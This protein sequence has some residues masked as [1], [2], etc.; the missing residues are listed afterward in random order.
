MGKNPGAKKQKEKKHKER[1]FDLDMGELQ[2]QA[3]L[4]G[5][6][7]WELQEVKDR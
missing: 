1:E 7:V 5:K 2:E 4:E 6:E 3:A